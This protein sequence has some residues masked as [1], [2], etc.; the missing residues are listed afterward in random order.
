LHQKNR[1]KRLATSLNHRHFIAVIKGYNNV[2]RRLKLTFILMCVLLLSACADSELPQWFSGEPT[3]AELDAYKG[4]IAMPAIDTAEKEW[5]N[6]ADVPERP[7]V[8]LQ[9]AEKAA[10][11]AE[12]KAKNTQGN[13]QVDVFNGKALPPLKPTI[14]SALKKSKKKKKKAK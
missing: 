12:L 3:R 9:P 1:N 10:L 2:M 13:N 5:P 7:T 4:P 8:L 14:K 6:L 11:I